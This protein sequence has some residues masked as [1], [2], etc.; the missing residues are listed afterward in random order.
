MLNMTIISSQGKSGSAETA[1][2]PDSKSVFLTQLT[3]YLSVPSTS[4]NRR[5]HV[6]LETHAGHKVNLP[7]DGYQPSYEGAKV[8]VYVREQPSISYELSSSAEDY[9]ELLADRRQLL[10]E[11]VLP[12]LRSTGSYR[13]EIEPNFFIVYK[14]P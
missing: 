8:S 9:S 2:E 3:N 6:I 5:A 7:E 11:L 13:L 14:K 12:F 4:G 10:E 1:P